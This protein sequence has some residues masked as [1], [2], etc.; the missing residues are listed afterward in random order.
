MRSKRTKRINKKSYKKRSYRKSKKSKRA[1]RVKGPKRKRTRKRQ[2]G[3]MEFRRGM[4]PEAPEQGAGAG[5]GRDAAE[6]G[7]GAEGGRDAAEQGA[8]AEGGLWASHAEHFTALAKAQGRAHARPRAPHPT[9]PST[10]A[11]DVSVEVGVK[12]AP[13]ATVEAEDLFGKVTVTVPDQPE[14][15]WG[16]LGKMLEQS[17]EAK[18]APPPQFPGRRIRGGYTDEEA[19]AAAAARSTLAQAAMLRQAQ[20]ERGLVMNRGAEIS[21]KQHEIKQLYEEYIS[22]KSP[23]VGDL[24]DQLWLNQQTDYRSTD[25]AE[26]ARKA[27]RRFRDEDFGMLD[28]IIKLIKSNTPE[29]PEIGSKIYNEQREQREL[30]LASVKGVQP[31]I[32]PVSL[33]PMGTSPEQYRSKTNWV[34]DTES[35]RCMRCSALFV[36]GWGKTGKHHCRGCGILVCDNCSKNTLALRYIQTPRCKIEGNTGEVRV[37]LDCFTFCETNLDCAGEGQ[38]HILSHYCED[39]IQ[40]GGYRK[41]NP[42][43][44]KKRSYRKSK[45]SK[46]SSRKTRRSFL[47]KTRAKATR[48]KAKEKKNKR[49][50]GGSAKVL[51]DRLSQAGRD[52]LPRGELDPEVVGLD[53]LREEQAT[54]TRAEEAKEAVAGTAGTA[55]RATRETEEISPLNFNIRTIKKLLKQHDFPIGK[56]ESD[57]CLREFMKDFLTKFPTNS[58]LKNL[59]DLHGEMGYIKANK[60]YKMAETQNPGNG[61]EDLQTA[62]FQLYHADE[63]KI[64]HL[65]QVL[66]HDITDIN[67]INLRERALATIENANGD[68]RV[69]F[70]A[71]FQAEH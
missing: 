48:A 12:P 54:L 46:R 15:G 24:R 69:A 60:Y 66:G 32:E 18:G 25:L 62:A 70:Q 16:E 10:V 49:M 64:D 40:G 11:S 9:P 21:K 3:G 20:E 36:K 38:S 68:I 71:A 29:D 17:V 65:L 39:T 22:K 23:P 7:A 1:K 37:C 58:E 33:S 31:G 61:K 30:A 56:C 26:I 28:E 42:K 34:P 52:D 50:I 47:K 63:E 55:T 44:Y 67:D 5:G 43:T 13:G 14:S 6:Q 35:D 27:A 45:K 59:E 4:W 57:T 41:S 8:G 19:A 2:D 53:S 51:A